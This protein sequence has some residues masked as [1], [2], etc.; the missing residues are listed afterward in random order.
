MHNQV[1]HKDIFKIKD[2]EHWLMHRGLPWVET[3][4]V[5]VLSLSLLRRHLE[6]QLRVY[7]AYQRNEPYMSE[8]HYGA[9]HG[10]AISKAVHDYAQLTH[11]N[12]Y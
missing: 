12:L 6:F 4:L 11:T 9:M 7:V 3:R 5:K 8:G 10:G 1:K 2:K